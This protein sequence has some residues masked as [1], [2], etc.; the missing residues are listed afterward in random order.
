M[1]IVDLEALDSIVAIKP[2]KGAL[3]QFDL[4]SR[5]ASQ[6]PLYDRI[7]LTQS[8]PVRSFYLCGIGF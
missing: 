8:Y 3:R 5:L 2:S 4:A 6:D 1:W 7:D